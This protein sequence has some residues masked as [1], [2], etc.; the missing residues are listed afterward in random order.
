MRPR[1]R[2]GQNFLRDRTFLQKIL[3]AADLQPNDQVL[4]IGSGT[5]VLTAE[6]VKAAA[7]LIAIELD[8]ALAN[9]L[10]A[11]YAGNP[12]VTVW[13]GNALDFDPCEHFDTP[14]KLLGNIPY[15]IT[16]PI[17]RHYLESACTPSVMVLMVQREVA[18]RMVAAP[19]HLSLLGVSVQFYA[20]PEIVSRVPPG[21]FYP[22]PRVE[23]AIVRLV[24]RQPPVPRGRHQRFFQLARAGFGTRRKTLTNALGIGLYISRDEARNLLDAAGIDPHRRAETLTLGEWARLAEVE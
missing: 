19:G 11:D 23:S 12:R 17:L 10:S 13:H 9:T 7:K 22:P 5:G 6:I 2:L 21:A 24:P 8:D 1:K 14:Y 18:Q 4:E 20:Q 16:G 3:D 15:Y